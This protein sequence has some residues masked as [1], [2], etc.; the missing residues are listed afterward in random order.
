MFDPAC[1][2]GD[3][4][5]DLAMTELF[6]GFGQDFYTAY[7]D[8]WQLDSGYQTRKSLYNLYHVLNHVNLFGSSYV[9]QAEKIMKNLLQEISL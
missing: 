2:F 8:V 4:E 5:T 1:Y 9:S 3:R 6:G 7:N